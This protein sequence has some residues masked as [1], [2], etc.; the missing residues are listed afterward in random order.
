LEKPE[1]EGKNLRAALCGQR[2]FEF[3]FALR[4]TLLLVRPSARHVMEKEFEVSL[5]SSVGIHGL[6]IFVSVYLFASLT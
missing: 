4:P 3:E 5:S 2:H 1:I 6:T